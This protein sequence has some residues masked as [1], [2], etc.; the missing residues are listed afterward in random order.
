VYHARARLLYGE[1]LRR[2]RRRS[3]A[4][5]QLR[6]AY[7]LFTAMG[8]EAFSARAARELLATGETLRKRTAESADQL[9]AREVQIARLAGEGLANAEIGARLCFSHRTVEYHL[10][11]VFTILDIHSRA[12]LKRALPGDI[13]AGAPSPAG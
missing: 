6:S 13:E 3:E 11:K 12:E 1:W 2:H 10:T 8:A 9:T 7:E 4:R 5:E